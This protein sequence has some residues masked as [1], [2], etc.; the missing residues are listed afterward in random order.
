MNT[1]Q[2]YHLYLKIGCIVNHKLISIMVPHHLPVKCLMITLSQFRL[3]NKSQPSINLILILI[4]LI[5][6]GILLL[7]IE[8]MVKSIINN[9]KL[10][11]YKI[12]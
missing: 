12:N 5:N 11:N 6:K 4:E 1:L 3:N 9:N 8:I 7:K 2:N 10:C